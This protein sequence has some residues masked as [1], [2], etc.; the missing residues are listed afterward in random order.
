MMLPLPITVSGVSSPYF[1][2][3]ASC[4]MLNIDWTPLYGISPTH[5]DSSPVIYFI[6]TVTVMFLKSCS[7]SKVTTNKTQNAQ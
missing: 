3:D 5:E 2:H 7:A 4:V 6:L 1:A